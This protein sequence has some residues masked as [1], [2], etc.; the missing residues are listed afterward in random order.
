MN[1]TDDWHTQ[2]DAYL[3]YFQDNPN[4]VSTTQVFPKIVEHVGNLKSLRVLD[5]GCG[6]GR[7]ARM[8]ADAGANVT[9][10]DSSSAEIANARAL[11]DN[12][13]IHY[14]DNQEEL[15][16]VEPFDCIL[17]FMVLLCNEV[18]AADDLLGTLHSLAKPGALIALANTDTS[19]IGRRF[20]DFYSTPPE[21][22]T[23]G[24]SYQSNIPTSA[25]LIQIVDHYYSPE[26]IRDM[27]NHSGF[28]VVIEDLTTEPFALHIGK[29]AE[30]ASAV[31]G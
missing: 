12:R 27:L 5:F 8:L 23:R 4:R 25:G 29:R 26:H 18:D 1:P 31:T 20:P 2:A 21:H 3:A 22:P 6:Q 7:F 16:D 19:T 13:N 28:D 17:C 14:V 11:D 30:A 15:H 24:A 9:A 10:Y